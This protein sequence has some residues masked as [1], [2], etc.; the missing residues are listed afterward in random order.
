MIRRCFCKSEY[1]DRKYG[2]G[3]RVFNKS[4]LGWR[5]TSCGKLDT[6]KATIARPTEVKPKGKKP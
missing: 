1:Q 2:S 5:C 4:K 6:I 3:N